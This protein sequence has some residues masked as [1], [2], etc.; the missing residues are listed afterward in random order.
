[1]FP[2]HGVRSLAG[3][4]RSCSHVAWQY[5][6]NNKMWS[7]GLWWR[8]RTG[9]CP[10]HVQCCAVGLYHLVQKIPCVGYHKGS[11]FSKCSISTANQAS[12]HIFPKKSLCY[13]QYLFFVLL[14]VSKSP[15][16]KW[17]SSKSSLQ[18]SS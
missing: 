1:M 9:L 15:L 3:E 8:N 17:A 4:Q 13:W 6:Y 14:T 12:S 7:L 18:A 2:L 5:I 10:N 11:F 16:L